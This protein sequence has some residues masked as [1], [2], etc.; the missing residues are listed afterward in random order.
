M[1]VQFP[2]PPP[3]RVHCYSEKKKTTLAE[4][5]KTLTPDSTDCIEYRRERERNCSNFETIVIVGLDLNG[6]TEEGKEGR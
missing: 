4:I 5:R 1:K 2:V 3:V 6:K